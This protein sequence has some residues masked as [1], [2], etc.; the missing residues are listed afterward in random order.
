MAAS[1]K[2]VVGVVEVGQSAT[3]EVKAAE[4]VSSEIANSNVAEVE[5]VVAVEAGITQVERK[6]GCKA[7]QVA[8]NYD[9]KKVWCTA[10]GVYWATSL[11]KKSK[12]PKNRG[13]IEEYTFE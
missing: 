6:N 5:V 9:A 10:D 8:K 4:A 1:K 3:P 13:E 12:L 2:V 11:E 7:A